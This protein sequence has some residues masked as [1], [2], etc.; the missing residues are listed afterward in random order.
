MRNDGKSYAVSARKAGR[1]RL[2]QVTRW[3]TP[4]IDTATD[5]VRK[6]PVTLDKNRFKLITQKLK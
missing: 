3:E 2:R 6:N 5:H 1:Q 4:D